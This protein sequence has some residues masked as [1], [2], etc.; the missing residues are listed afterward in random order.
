MT[1]PN[2]FAAVRLEEEE[3]ELVVTPSREVS[4]DLYVGRCV[5]GAVGNKVPPEPVLMGLLGAV[6][7]EG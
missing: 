6:G 7:A 1:N 5:G 3:A 2:L 4:V